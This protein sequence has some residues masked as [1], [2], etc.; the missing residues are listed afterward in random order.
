MQWKQRRATEVSIYLYTAYLNR[1][2]LKI[3]PL[4]SRRGKGLKLFTTISFIDSFIHSFVHSCNH[5][6]IRSLVI[7]TIIHLFIRAIIHSFVHL[8]IRTIFHSFI[9]SQP[10]GQV[11][12]FRLLGWKTA[13][14]TFSF[15]WLIRLSLAILTRL[16]ARLLACS[17]VG[18][19]AS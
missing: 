8:F 16:L 10:V 7:R 13:I 9:Q 3:R 11:L 4:G 14:Y 5:S 15:V 2:I 17:L 18:L 1:L 12:S 19:L 6:F